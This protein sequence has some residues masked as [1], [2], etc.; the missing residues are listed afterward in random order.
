MRRADRSIHR[1]PGGPLGFHSRQLLLGGGL[2]SA[3]L[4]TLLLQLGSPGIRPVPFGS[5]GGAFL[6]P[7]GALCL[8]L[9]KQPV[10]FAGQLGAGPVGVLAM[11]VE[12]PSVFMLCGL[13]LLGGCRLRLL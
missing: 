3:G 4:I 11:F 1:L 7:C 8:Q 5:G 9:V 10:T 6:L 12:R 2:R 13:Q